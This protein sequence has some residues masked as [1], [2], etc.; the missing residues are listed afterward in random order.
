MCFL[1]RHYTYRGNIRYLLLI[2]DLVKTIQ[3]NQKRMEITLH[4]QTEDHAQEL[5]I[6]NLLID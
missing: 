6:Q 2:I 5:L 1:I 3:K 4:L